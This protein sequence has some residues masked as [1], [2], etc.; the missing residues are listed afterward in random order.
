MGA[1]A[2]GNERRTV[3]RRATPSELEAGRKALERWRDDP[4][5]YSR[6]VLAFEPWSRQA[7]IIRAL[8][9][10]RFV[11]AKSGHKIGKSDIAAVASHWFTGTKPDSR[12]ILTAPSAHQIQNIVWRSVKRLY[13]RAGRV[14]EQGKRHGL[15]LG[16][17]CYDTAHVGLRYSDGREIIGLSTDVPERFAGISAPNLLFIVDEASGVEEKIFEAIFGNTAGNAWVLLLSNP[18]RTSGTFYDAFHTKRSNWHTISVASTETPN[19]DPNVE[20]IP[21][22]ASPQFLEFA[23]RQW[24]IDSPHFSVRVMGEFPSQSENSVIGVGL[25]NEATARWEPFD[26]DV[27]ND[28]ETAPE[29][30]TFGVD[31]A[32]FGDDSTVIQGGRGKRTLPPITLHNADGPTVAA[33]VCAEI[34]RWRRFDETAL[35]KCDGINAGASVFDALKGLE[36]AHTFEVVAVNVA[37]QADDPSEYPNLRSQ[38][39]FDM[40]DWLRAGGTLPRTKTWRPS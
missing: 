20:P 13:D 2:L 5:T 30:L 38:L 26:D 31:V 25:I 37:E 18:T 24:G 40:R 35:V 32:R 6:E 14:D 19:F 28:H 4:V 7:E 21:G 22:L 27:N 34:D 11:A 23:K 16:G 8:T 29:R 39:W 36:A 1:Q 10:H 15:T 17:E 33:A 3:S 9:T 12:V